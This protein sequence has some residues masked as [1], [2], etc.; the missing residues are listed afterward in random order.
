[1]VSP[2]GT[3]RASA[4]VDGTGGWLRERGD[5]TWRSSVK[6]NNFKG[7][8]AEKSSHILKQLYFLFSIKFVIN[9]MR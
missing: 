8:L 6:L 1:M 7:T 9:F 3:S 2:N 4:S 5:K